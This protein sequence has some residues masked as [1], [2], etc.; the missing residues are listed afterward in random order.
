MAIEY[1]EIEI[2]VSELQLGMHVVRLDRPWA[3]TDFL[4]QGFIIDNDDVIVALTS[5]CKFVY[6]IGR[7]S[8]RERV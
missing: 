6:K 1:T 4:M 5:Q 2:P 8:C 7:A 3:E